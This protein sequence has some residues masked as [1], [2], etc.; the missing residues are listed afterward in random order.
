MRKTYGSK[1]AKVFWF[2]FTKKNCLLLVFMLC[3]SKALAAD[4]SIT[5]HGVPSNRGIVLATLCSKENFLQ[6]ICPWRGR[7]P[8]Q[9]GDVHI[10][11]SGVPPGIYAVQAFHDENGNGHLDTN[12]LGIPKEAMGFSNDAPMHFGPPDFAVASF[13]V[14]A[15]PV[16]V[17]FSL[18]KY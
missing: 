2:F 17:S 15:T 9:Q 8:A 13:R 3:V 16:A 7:A 6:P 4:I 12:F 5:I 11:L 1:P 10:T 14:G 18:K